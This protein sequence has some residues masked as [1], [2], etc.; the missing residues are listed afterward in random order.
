MVSVSIRVSSCGSDLSILY[1]Q[2]ANNFF[3]GSYQLNAFWGS[4]CSHID[5]SCRERCPP[6]GVRKTRWT[7][8]CLRA[9]GACIKSA[10]PLEPRV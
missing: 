1:R 9:A 10:K 3:H 5:A 2:A 7:E 6:K 4:F 8:G